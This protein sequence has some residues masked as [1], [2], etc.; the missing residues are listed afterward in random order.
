MATISPVVVP[1]SG[2]IPG[3]IKNGMEIEV[4]GTVPHHAHNGFSIN[5]CQG[6]NV[7]PTTVLHFNVRLNQNCIVLNHM[8]NNSWGGEVR[9]DGHQFHKGKP[10]DLR[11]LIKPQMYKLK[12]NGRHIVDFAHRLP[13]ETAQFIVVQGE[14]SVNYIRFQSGGGGGGGAVPAPQPAYGPQ[15]IYNPPVPFVQ[16]IPGGLSPGRMIHI[17]GVPFPTASRITINL[18]SG[19]YDGCDVAFHC[20]IRFRTDDG[21]F[22]TI[23]RNHCQGGAWGL[24]DRS[25]PYFPF[26]PNNNFDILL[27]TEAHGF[28]VA[29]N[30]QHLLEFRHRLPMQVANTLRV[31]G[32]VR[33][34]Q[35][36]FQ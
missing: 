22:N 16:G 27:L 20:D 23:V 32:D 1:Y 11:I 4:Q 24:E 8:Q 18:Q 12:V 36:R 21:S 29:V 14:V 2:G 25:A 26:V 19:P 33:L 7:E 35:I 5:L 9:H 3:G 30:N 15:P 28:K 6:P 34:T 31:T 10:F 13:K 17:S